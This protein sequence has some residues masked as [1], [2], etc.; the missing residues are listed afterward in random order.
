MF[1]KMLFTRLGYGII[2]VT[3]VL[4]LLFFVLRVIPGDPTATIAPTATEERRMIIK[5]SLDLDQPLVIQYGMFVKDMLSGNFGKSFFM[6]EVDIMGVVAIRAFNS[7]KIALTAILITVIGSILLGIS[8]ASKAG[9]FYDRFIIGLT[10]TMQSIPNFWLGLILILL[11]GVKLG[12][13]PTTGYR[14]A[15]SI[16]VPSLVLAISLLGT[17]TR[18]VRVCA[19]DILKS[20]FI[21]AARARGIKESRVLYNYTLKNVN[22][23]LLTVASLQFGIMIGGIVIIEFVFDYPGLGL[24]TLNAILR[25]DYPLIQAIV[26]VIAVLFVA[27]NLIT[28]L[29][30]YLKDPRIRKVI[31]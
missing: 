26:L 8:S 14:G 3:G 13:V 12:W 23:F 27:I 16:I 5:K 22:L 25:R 11:F 17:M 29:I 24:L 21:T 28:D 30:Y 10:L 7:L 19:V 15:V 9:T 6:P 4:T 31:S 20:D 18:L 1:L 2:V